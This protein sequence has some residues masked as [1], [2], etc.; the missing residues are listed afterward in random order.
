MMD[1]LWQANLVEYHRATEQTGQKGAW[2]QNKRTH[3]FNDMA[4]VA[5][6]EES[7]AVLHVDLHP[8]QPCERSDRM[9]GLFRQ[10]NSP[11]VWP[12]K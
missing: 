8:D 3:I 1:G 5:D 11:S 12:G 10:G 4:V 2:Q 9:S 7:A 6:E